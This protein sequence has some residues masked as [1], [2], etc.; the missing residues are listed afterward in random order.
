MDDIPEKL[1]QY[2]GRQSLPAGAAER[3]LALG[4][5]AGRERRRRRAFF[6]SMA[7][8]LALAAG[9]FAYRQQVARSR[10]E[11]ADVEIAMQAFFNRPDYQLARVSA[12]LPELRSW[13]Q[14]EGG[15]AGAGLPAAFAGLPAYGCH[16]LQVREQS[17]YLLCFFLDP[18]D[19]TSAFS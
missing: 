14:R 8:M 6:W 4:R 19:S 3:I 13:L 9:G 18:A 5:E 7:A 10:V 2:Y 15:P 11:A 12:D 1:R 17:V 16:V